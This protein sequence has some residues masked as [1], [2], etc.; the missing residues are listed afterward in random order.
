MENKND[1]NFIANEMYQRIMDKMPICTVDVIF[2]NKEKNKIL[3]F[4]RNNE[5]LKNTY[6]TIG[7]RLF[8][9]E[10]FLDCALRKAKEE[11]NLKLDPKKT[12]LA[13]VAQE[14]CKNSIFKNISYYAVDVFFLYI[15][16]NERVDV[17]FDEQHNNYK[18]FSIKDKTLHPFIKEKIRQTLLAIKK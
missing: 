4:K 6:F 9:G 10:S 7:G 13:G 2:L 15:L 17:K 11:L 14:N 18:W 5:P 1:V 3:L 12:I 16:K 8:K